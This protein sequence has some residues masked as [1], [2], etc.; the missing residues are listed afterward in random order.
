VKKTKKTSAQEKRRQIIEQRRNRQ[1]KA[2][3]AILVIAIAGEAIYIA[4]GTKYFNIN[5]IRMYGNSR[6]SNEKI[7]KLSGLSLNDNIFRVDTGLAAKRIQGEPWIKKA[8]VT[9]QLPLTVKIQVT[10]RQPL[11]I[12]LNG[13]SYY[14]LDKEGTVIAVGTAPPLAGLPLIKDAA[15]STGLDIGEPVEESAVKNALSVIAMLDKDILADIG[16]V[17][18]PTI[19]GLA[20]KLNSGPVVMYGKAEMTKQKNYALKVIQTEATNE[21]KIWQYIDVRVPSNPVAKAIA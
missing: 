21:G 4:S 5:K 2:V 10:E 3:I 13:P 8:F 14:L 9:R 7:I 19:D 16:W 15:P 1:L 6:I 17:S 11:A 12:W 20:I 18:A